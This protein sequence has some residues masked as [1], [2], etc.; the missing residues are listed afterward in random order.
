[1]QPGEQ[2]LFERR[3]RDHRRIGIVDRKVGLGRDLAQYQQIGDRDKRKDDPDRCVAGDRLDPAQR[4][5][6]DVG[7]HDCAGKGQQY[8]E[9]SP[10]R[11]HVGP[12]C[13]ARDAGLACLQMHNVEQGD[14]RNYR[15]QERV[16]DDLRIGHADVLGHQECRRAHHRRH[17][18]AINARSDL[19]RA[20]LCR[21]VA[22]ALHQRNRERAAGHDIGDRRAGNHAHQA[23][24]DHRSLRWSAPHVAEQRKRD[25]DE[26]V[27]GA[28]FFQQRAEQHEKEDIACRYS[29]S[30][31]EHPLGRQPV[32]RNGLAQ[33][34]P[35]VRDH[36]GHVRPGECVTEHQQRDDRERR[37]DDAPCRFQQK[38]HAKYRS[39][40]VERGRLA[41]SRRDLGI[42]Q[43]QIGAAERGHPRQCPVLQWDAIARRALGEGIREIGEKQPE[44]KMQRSHLCRVE[45]ENVEDEWQRRC[46]PELQ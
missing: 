32:V 30:N 27:A 38:Q 44:A 39:R 40:D 15:R 7:Q 35:L 1:M 17:D 37:A 45:I 9:Q 14:V 12:A 11:R 2:G 5:V 22:D 31:A 21:A 28:S 43:E 19:D 3:Q 8:V 10:H 34:N 25:L 36:L 24:R 6:N 33:R 20:C 42:E 18:L 46:V 41:G 26:I 13:N 29:Q 23:R 4:V 16:L